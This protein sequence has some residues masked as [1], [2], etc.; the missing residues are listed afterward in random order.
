MPRL[1]RA[2][3][4]FLGALDGDGTHQDRLALGVTLLDIVGNG[5]VLGLDG[6]VHQILVVNA[7]HGLVGGMTSTGSL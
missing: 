7:L 2:A 4:S 6:A 5:V 3:D 1:V